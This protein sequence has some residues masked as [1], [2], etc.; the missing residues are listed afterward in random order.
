MKFVKWI[1]AIVL[2][3]VVL[4]MVAF[5]VFGGSIVKTAVNRAGPRIM[6]VPV[7]VDNVVF[8][9]LAG[10]FVLEK[11]HIG[12]P[13]GFETDYLIEVDS[14]DLE[15]DTASLFSDTIRIGSIEVAAPRICYEQG[16]RSSN[17]STLMK[18]MESSEPAQSEE[19]ELD[20]E[21]D[22]APGKKVVID[23]FLMTEPA[24][25]FSAPAVQGKKVSLVLGDVELVDI[26]K[27]EG[28]I[29][30]ANAVRLVMS[31]LA[32]NIQ[33]AAAQAGDLVGTGA[34]MIKER[35]ET[36]ADAARDAAQQ[37]ETTAKET[38]KALEEQADSVI[39]GLGGLFGGDDAKKDSSGSE[40][41]E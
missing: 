23:R 1:L 27:D 5:L 25:N 19:A 34:D 11:L 40:G 8:R 13:K 31:V 38:V 10:K 39:K 4:L 3:L 15:M 2:L 20:D 37:A 22:A 32:S 36:T 14:V 30:P 18:Q 26:G 9:P 6:G 12:N 41:G 17:F 28:G 7:T 21:G 29:S 35:A 33:E 24:L 16:L